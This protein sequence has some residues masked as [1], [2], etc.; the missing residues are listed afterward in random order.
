[1]GSTVLAEGSRPVLPN[2]VTMEEYE[3]LFSDMINVVGDIEINK[4]T[5]ISIPVKSG[6]LSGT[7]IIEEKPDI[8]QQPGVTPFQIFDG[9]PDGARTITTTF[10]ADTFL[11]GEL[12]LKSNYT[13]KN[14][15]MA[16]TVTSTSEALSPPIGYTNG[17]TTSYIVKSESLYFMTKGSYTMLLAGLPLTMRVV[18]EVTW[19]TKGTISLS[20]YK[21][22]WCDILEKGINDMLHYFSNL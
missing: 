19:L 1:M 11:G 22:I 3:K 4:D 15:G 20:A 6:R 21:E 14:N 7:V 5:T 17:G 9:I 16:I 8:E 10:K 13:M 12:V 18:H 2:N